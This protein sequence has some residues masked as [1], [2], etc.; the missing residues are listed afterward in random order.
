MKYSK[1]CLESNVETNVRPAL[2][3]VHDTSI[4]LYR[5]GLA[6]AVSTENSKK[7]LGRVFTHNELTKMD[8]NEV[9]ALYTEYTTRVGRS[10]GDGINKMA[11]SAYT[12]L[13]KRL[14]PMIDHSALKNDLNNNPVLQHA[15]CVLSGEIF[16]RFGLGVAPLTLMLSTIQHVGVKG[17]A[18]VAQVISILI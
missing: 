17:L 4:E 5:S 7:P 15:L 13:V 8:P 2:T 11:T 16:H 1:I 9:T 12:G 18:W 14:F 3:P 6:A 10:M